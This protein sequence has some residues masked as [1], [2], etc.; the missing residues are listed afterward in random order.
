MLCGADVGVYVTDGAFVTASIAPRFVAC[1]SSAHGSSLGTQRAFLMNYNERTGHFGRPRFYTYGNAPALATHFDGITAV[2]GGF[3]LV[4]V[5]S[6]Q[7]SSMAFVP[8]VGDWPSFGKATWYPIDVA[9]SRLCS[10][11][12]AAAW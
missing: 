11:I 7:A 8:A 4:A 5:S 3:N 6:A 1:G 12:R 9:K 10:K 2:P